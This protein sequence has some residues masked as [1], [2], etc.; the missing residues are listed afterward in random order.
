[1]KFPRPAATSASGAPAEKAMRAILVEGF[2]EGGE[3]F[4]V[5][6]L[7]SFVGAG[8]GSGGGG[9][10]EDLRA[11]EG[12]FLEAEDAGTARK[13][14]VDRFAVEGDDAGF[15][16]FDFTGEKDAA[17]GEFLALNFFHAFGGALDQVGEADAEFDEAFVFGVFERL[18]DDTGIVHDGPKM[19]AAAGVIVPGACRAFAG[20]A[21]DEDE[22]HTFA[23]IVWK[24]AHGIACC[25]VPLLKRAVARDR[26]QL[27]PIARARSGNVRGTSIL[28][29]GESELGGILGECCQVCE[30]ARVTVGVGRATLTQAVS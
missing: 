10:D 11:V 23:K 5:A 4:E 12:V 15:H 18:G 29:E 1:M 28:A 26:T 20:I 24:R 22:L 27:P 8:I 2:E 14:L 16:F 30:Q 21:A 25:P 6:H 17:L 19:I 9:E 7:D 13:A 3:L